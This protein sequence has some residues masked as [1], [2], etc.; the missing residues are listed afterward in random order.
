MA[1][2]VIVNNQRGKERKKILLDQRD[3][4]KEIFTRLIN[5]SSTY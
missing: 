5:I 4:I 2:D 1:V 3:I